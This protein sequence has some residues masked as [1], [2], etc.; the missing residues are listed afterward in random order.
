[1]MAA[2]G[3]QLRSSK[4]TSHPLHGRR[5]FEYTA[6]DFADTMEAQFDPHYNIIKNDHEDR[7]EEFIDVYFDKIPDD[8][9]AP[10]T[11]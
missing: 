8:I 6:E 4:T 3:R 10:L 7:V 9:I 5:G 1:M 11:S 2:L